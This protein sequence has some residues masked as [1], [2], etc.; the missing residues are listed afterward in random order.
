VSKENN[1]ILDALIFQSDDNSAN[2]Q[3]SEVVE[4]IM[5]PEAGFY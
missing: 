3:P 2:E 4:E 5:D 1:D